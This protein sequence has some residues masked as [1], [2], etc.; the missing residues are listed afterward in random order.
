MPQQKQLLQPSAPP[1]FIP[2]PP[3]TRRQ[4]NQKL[5]MSIMSEGGTTNAPAPPTVTPIL[6]ISSIE[7]RNY[8]GN[9]SAYAYSN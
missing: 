1:F 3:V 4:L 9:K 8:G 6:P 5:K 2:N 7:K